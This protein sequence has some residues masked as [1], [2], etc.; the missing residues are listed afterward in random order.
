[1]DL[2]GDLRRLHPEI[3]LIAITGGE[4][5]V[6]RDLLGRALELGAA[7]ALRKPFGM[8]SLLDVVAA[9]LSQRPGGSNE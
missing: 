1:L 5:R 6:D 8:T 7:A 3:P 4:A 2:V 9:V